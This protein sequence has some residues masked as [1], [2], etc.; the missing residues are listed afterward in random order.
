MVID[1]L[2]VDVNCCLIE[3]FCGGFNPI[4]ID[5]DMAC[6]QLAV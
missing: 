6:Y 1:L 5:I 4:Y 2:Q 3:L